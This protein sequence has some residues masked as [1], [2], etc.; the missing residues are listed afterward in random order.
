M[1]KKALKKIERFETAGTVDFTH[2]ILPDYSIRLLQIAPLLPFYDIDP[3]VVQFVGTGVW[4]NEIFFNER[5]L[6]KSIFPGV[7]KSKRKDYFDDYYMYYN[8]KPMRTI[9][10]PYDLVGI[11]AY[12]INNNYKTEDVFTLLNDQS[13]N[14]DGI[15]GRFSFNKNIIT[16]KLNILKILEGKAVLIE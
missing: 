3:N 2:L 15:D 1:S 8:H 12:I 5:S 10:M 14:F 6:Q 16:R 13:N 7:N 11:I 9:T 4:D